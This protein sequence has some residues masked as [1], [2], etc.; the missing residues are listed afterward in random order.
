M[1]AVFA[2]AACRLDANIEV[3]TARDGSGTVTVTAVAD[4]DMIGRAGLALADLRLDDAKK[5]DWTVE[6]PTDNG[7]GGRQLVLSKPF[8]TQLEADRILGEL[9]GLAG[10]L[11]DFHLKQKRDFAKI[12]TTLSGELGLDGGAPGL[13][14]DEL[15]A[16]LGGHQVLEGLASENLADQLLVTVSL[17]APGFAKGPAA[18]TGP[19]DGTSRT[20]IL[21]S[22]VENDAKASKARRLSYLAFAGIV[23]STWLSV[24]LYRRRKI[25]ASRRQT[26][27]RR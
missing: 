27:W 15:V 13:G 23:A 19:M 26:V 12:T 24:M 4:R 16:L 10:P 2:C 14:D 1:V 18:G 17:K 6:G 22:S 9:S 5:A 21:L 25:A 11:H 7:A 3:S 8:Q 20:R